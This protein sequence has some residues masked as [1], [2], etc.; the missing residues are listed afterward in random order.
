MSTAT[1]NSRGSR[2]GSAVRATLA[3]IADRLT[4]RRQPL[5]LRDTDRLDGKTCLVTGANSG[6]GKA[7]AAELGRR[8]AEI[9]MAGRTL[10]EAARDEIRRAA[11]HERVEL[12]HLELGRLES[13]AAFCRRQ[14]ELDRRFDVTVLNAGIVP[15]A[16]RRTEDGFEE[17]FQ[18]NYLANYALV[19]GLLEGGRIE[20]RPAA[21]P[22]IVL[23][24]S[25]SHRS[26]AALDW[27]RFGAFAEYGMA[28]AVAEY[29]RTKL[30]LQTLAAELARRLAPGGRVDIAVHSLCPGA[31][32]SRLAREAPAW[33]KPLLW[34]VL[35]AFFRSPERAAES[36]VAL[37][38]ASAY[39][40]RTGV[41]LHQTTEKA[42]APHATD[43][44]NGRR[45]WEA[46]AALLRQGPA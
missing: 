10:D 4:S 18:V 15:R 3:G 33:A 24:S 26:A 34:L 2:H 14:A 41:Y 39:E 16:S 45:L 12:E 46:S 31:V 20:G 25:D 7:I 23:V 40:G 9:V 17:G 11:G 28:G 38:C 8:G 36:A 43:P 1:P 32:K 44:E 35:A 42:P 5:P 6:L 13:V 37:C 19:R 30:M 29:G 27:E 21:P 22:R